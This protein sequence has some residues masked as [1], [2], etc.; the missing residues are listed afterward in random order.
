[1]PVRLGAPQNVS[2]LSEVINNPIY[3]TGVGLLVYA[4]QQQYGGR[5]ESAINPGFKGLWGRMQSWFKGNF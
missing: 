1:M 3:A 5:S 4:K 2:G